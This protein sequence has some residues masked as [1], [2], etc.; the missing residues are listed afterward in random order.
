M[1][2]KLY[3]RAAITLQGRVTGS[4]AGENDV[5]RPHLK[6]QIQVVVWMFSSHSR[7]QRHTSSGFHS[8]LFC[9]NGFTT[10][11]LALFSE[12]ETQ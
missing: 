5:I 10:F 6:T 4:S 9:F 3:C 8:L 11:M 7:M 12:E 2:D 1:V